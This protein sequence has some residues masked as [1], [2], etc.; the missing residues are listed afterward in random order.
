LRRA[1]NAEQLGDKRHDAG[2][3]VF[4]G[5]GDESETRGHF[6]I[7]EVAFCAAG[8][9]LPLARQN[10]KEVAAI[11]SGRASAGFRIMSPFR[12]GSVSA[13][14]HGIEAK[15]NGQPTSLPCGFTMH[16]PA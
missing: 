9:M 5:I 15:A 3:A 4:G 10:M 13:T 2:G 1:R 14:A 8:R 6:G 7:H 16:H 11:G 12:A